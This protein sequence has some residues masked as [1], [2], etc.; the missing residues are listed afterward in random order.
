MTSESLRHFKD[1]TKLTRNQGLASSRDW[2]C[3][4]R[5][6]AESQAL[7]PPRGG[8]GGLQGSSLGADRATASLSITAPEPPGACRLE[9]P[10]V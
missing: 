2:R 6:L 4:S 9:V 7:C 5:G 10:A 8:D 1:R 3:P